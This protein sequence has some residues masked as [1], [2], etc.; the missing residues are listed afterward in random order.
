MDER[1]ASICAAFDATLIALLSLRGEA[2]E[3]EDV[4]AGYMA[5]LANATQC[6]P[7][8]RDVERRLSESGVAGVEFHSLRGH[9]VVRDLSTRLLHDLECYAGVRSKEEL[10][11]YRRWNCNVFDVPHAAVIAWLEQ[12]STALTKYRGAPSLNGHG[13]RT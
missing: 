9:Y 5:V 12:R 8:A 7:V 3:L 1:S 4:R 2:A 13:N 6:G 10:P 11:L